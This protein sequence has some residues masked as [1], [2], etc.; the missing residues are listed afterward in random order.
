MRIDG[1]KGTLLKSIISEFNRIPEGSRGSYFPWFLR[2]TRLLDNK[3]LGMEYSESPPVP[4]TLK[5]SGT[6]TNQEN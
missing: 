2:N 3:S 5:N 4:A 1:A 6:H